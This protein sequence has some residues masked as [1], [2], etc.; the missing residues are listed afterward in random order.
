[1][2]A[3]GF[4]KSPWLKP[5]VVG[6]VAVVLFAAWML[7]DSGKPL[8]LRVP[9]TDNAPTGALGSKGNP[10]LAG[11]L[12]RGDGAPATNLPGAWPQFRGANLNSISPE[13]TR[14]LRAWQLGEP[15]ELWGV[16]VG[17]GY[18]G[19]AVWNGRVYLMDYDQQKK[20]DALRCL[21][22][23]DGKEIWR[24]AYPVSVKRNHGMSRTVPV[25][26]DN[27]VVAMGPK[28]HVVCL[29]AVTGE[30]QWGLD[31]V[32]E[33]GT[34]IPQWYAGQTPLIEGETVV[35]A[36]GGPEALVMAV[37][38][39]SGK[40]MWRTPNPRGW[41]MTHASLTPMD[42]AGE[43]FYVYCADKGVVGVSAKD[44]KLL[45]ETTDWKISIA[46]VP[47]PVV[48]E[49]GRIFFSGGYNAGSLMLQ[50]KKEG[51]TV[52]PVVAYRLGPGVFGATQHTPI[53]HQNHLYGVRPDGKFVCLTLD[54][55]TVWVSDSGH[56]FGLGPF[57]MA[58]GLIFAVNDSGLLRLIEA[59]PARY[60]LLGQAQVLKG[61]ESWG[62]L[63]LAG[64]RLL[65]RDFTRLVCLD[66]AQP[67]SVARP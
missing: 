45:W 2:K 12:I 11:K 63:A 50:L 13:Q 47:S 9:G 67:L 14:L 59:S 22:L 20:Q 65:A 61:R 28:C 1:M 16:D 30:L 27:R 54:G 31:L 23:G 36:P 33:Q 62:P 6:V 34:T 21:S 46:T 44:G 10:V 56:Q 40:P 8:T 19:A 4:L 24:Y 15:R 17:E 66:V 42:F 7:K 60:S 49:G 64:G 38:L 39:S 58:E 48:I 26:A 43:R 41:K 57:L 51:D 5:I 18:A 35:L 37:E 3:A 55:K 29:D 25:V 53:V 32:Q 52:L